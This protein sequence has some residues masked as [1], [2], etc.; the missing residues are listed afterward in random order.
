[1]R[2]TEEYGFRKYQRGKCFKE[3][4][5]VKY[6]S[7]ISYD[8]D[9]ELIVRFGK[10]KMGGKFDKEYFVEEAGKSLIGFTKPTEELNTQ[11]P[12]FF[13]FWFT[14]FFFTVSFKKYEEA[15]Y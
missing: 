1:M 2:G 14:F 15:Y 6:C 11:G 4:G 9:G 13:F 5:I 7:E 8:L 10:V 3:K 12:P